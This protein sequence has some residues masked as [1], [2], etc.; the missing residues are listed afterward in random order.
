MV[1]LMALAEGN[2]EP[3]LSRGLSDLRGTSISKDLLSKF[4]AAPAD[5]S[6]EAIPKPKSP[7]RKWTP[8]TSPPAVATGGAKPPPSSLKITVGPPPDV[9]SGS[10]VD[11][12]MSPQS[13]LSEN[14]FLQKDKSRAS[15]SDAVEKSEAGS[16]R[17]AVDEELEGAAARI[18]AA[19]NSFAASAESEKPPSSSSSRKASERGGSSSQQPAEEEDEEAAVAARVRA[20]RNSFSEREKQ[21]EKDPREVVQAERK[22]R[23][24]PAAPAESAAPVKL[25]EVALADPTAAAPPGTAAETQPEPEDAVPKVPPEEVQAEVSPQVEA[26][27]E[28][29][30][31]A[32]SGGAA[33]PPD[34]PPAAPSAAGSCCTIA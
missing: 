12:P 23:E 24:K 20:A 17:P 15:M 5:N 3:K 29:K 30:H 19:R 14:P 4:N 6:Y 25:E 2:D 28:A 26:Q 31:S 11:E 16:G 22:Q 10:K 34:A 33:Q 8:P 27:V 18:R 21:V 32:A 13:P 9:T 7:A 1:D